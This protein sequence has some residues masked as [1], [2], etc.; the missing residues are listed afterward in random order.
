M[1]TTPRCFERKCI[2][3]RQ[4]EEG[5]QGEEGSQ[6]LVCS[7]FPIEERGI[8]EDIA[9]GDNLHLNPIKGQKNTL[10]FHKEG[11]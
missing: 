8:P 5:V 1:L 3:F 2:H 4:V 10:V 11:T 7:A 9:Y 6:V